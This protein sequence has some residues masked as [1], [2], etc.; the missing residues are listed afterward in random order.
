MDEAIATLREQLAAAEKRASA[1]LIWAQSEV[2]ASAELK[3]AAIEER[4]AVL[5]ES[6]QT[7]LRNA[8][9]CTEPFQRPTARLQRLRE[10]QLVLQVLVQADEL[11]RTLELTATTIIAPTGGAPSTPVR[12]L[13]QLHVL[14][15]CVRRSSGGGAAV[16]DELPSLLDARARALLPSL[17]AP[18]EARVAK[19]L[20]NIGWP[21]AHM[22]PSSAALCCSPARRDRPCST[23]SAPHPAPHTAMPA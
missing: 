3:L 21:A 20:V 18:F 8:E 10:A 2:A 6:V 12:A 7:A 16:T 15:A 14:R 1:T 17:R 11:V 23:C 13:L 4:R 5:A 19:A 9:R 22:M